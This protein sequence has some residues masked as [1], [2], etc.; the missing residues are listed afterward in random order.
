M[1]NT[2]ETT[3]LPAT[4]LPTAVTAFVDGWQ[5]H[6]RAKVKALFAKDATVSDE[7]RTHR[8]QEEIDSWVDETIDLFSTTVT[9]L[10]ARKDDEMVGASYRIEGDFPGGVVE[11]EYQFRLN[12]DGRIVA[13]DFAS[14]AV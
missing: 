10:G 8:G 3:Q 5:A 1:E 2:R 9:F 12:D 11:L 4:Q 7:G 6:D 14:A 13:L